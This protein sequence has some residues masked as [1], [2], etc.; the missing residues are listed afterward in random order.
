[1]NFCWAFIIPETDC[2]YIP[3][4]NKAGK[5][6]LTLEQEQTQNCFVSI[7]TWIMLRVLEFIHMNQAFFVRFLIQVHL[8]LFLF[9]FLLFSLHLCHFFDYIYKFK[10]YLRIRL[11]KLN[12]TKIFLCKDNYKFFNM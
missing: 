10:K 1:M 2:M 6:T 8:L 5:Q 12:T 4:K 11:P 3:V 9:S 7:Q